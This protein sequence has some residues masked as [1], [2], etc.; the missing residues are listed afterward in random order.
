[1]RTDHDRQ[2][3]HTALAF[4]KSYVDGNGVELLSGV[5]S[6]EQYVTRL[7]ESV[8]GAATEIEGGELF[9]TSWLELGALHLTRSGFPGIDHFYHRAHSREQQMCWR[10]GW[11]FL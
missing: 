7:T 6:K 4:L 9:F 8:V 5:Q 1:M 3:I 2:W 10:Q 11:P